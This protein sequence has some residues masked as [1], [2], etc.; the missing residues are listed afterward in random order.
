M[1]LKALNIKRKDLIYIVITAI[2]IIVVIIVG[3][4][5]LNQGKAGSNSNTTVEVVK[6]IGSQLNTKTLDHLRNEKDATDF[7]LPVDLNSGVG[8]PA[9]FKQL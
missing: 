2:V 6:P 4:G 5:E 9:P 8:N 3:Y 1:N 7:S